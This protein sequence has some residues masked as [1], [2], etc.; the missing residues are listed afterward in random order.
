MEKEY[1]DEVFSSLGPVTVKR[2]FS[3]Q[4]IYFDGLII[5]AVMDGEILLKADEVSAPEFA[6]AGAEQWTYTYPSGKLAGKTIRMPYWNIPADALDNPQE[7][8]KWVGLAFEAAK[9]GQKR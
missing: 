8:E 4:G 5:A 6:Q 1:I 9:R 3:G 7:L 2:L